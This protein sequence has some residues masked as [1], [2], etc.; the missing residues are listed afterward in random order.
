[1][2]YLNTVYVTDHQAR[3]SRSKSSLIVTTPDGKQRIPLEAVDA[4]TLLGGGH[5]TTDAIAACAERQIRVACLRRGGGVRFT[6][7]GPRG[8]NVHL[9]VAQHRASGDDEAS[10]AIAKYIVAAKIQSSRR[11]LLR[12]ARDAA[13]QVRGPL[14]SRA[15]V[16]AARVS[17]IR[18]AG[19]ADHLRGIE[20]DA[21]RAYFAGMGMVLSGTWC[22]FTDRNR[23]PPRDPVNAL[24]GFSYGLLVT[25]VS[26]AAE[27]VGLDHQV[28][29]LHR[30]RSGR[31]SLA[32]DLAEEL[33]PLI[34]RFVVR[35]LRRH[36]L[37]AEHFTRTPGGATYLSD[38]GRAVFLRLWEAS[39]VESVD[40]V[41][42]RRPVERWA[43]P[44][45]QATLLARHLRG[46][47]PGYPPFLLAG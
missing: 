12:W 40:H 1:M 8:G 41:L 25:E 18:T 4:V 32:L 37:R 35:C 36:E 30:P 24:L 11:V 5:M 2:R 10:L 39:K 44:S 20:G 22:T 33:R 14:Q 43:L 38:E 17:R 3:I 16:M 23:R 26:G 9:R 45:V 42:L 29:F 15:D 6:I 27:A 47:I 34:D 46:D 31:P 21:A 28:G 19:D 7:A 13:P